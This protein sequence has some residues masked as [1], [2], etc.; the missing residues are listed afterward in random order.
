MPFSLPIGVKF[1]AEMRSFSD[2]YSQVTNHYFVLQAARLVHCYMH[3]AYY[4]SY[5]LYI[6]AEI[7]CTCI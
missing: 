1:H 4:S 6:M 2:S 5:L 7:C 3:T